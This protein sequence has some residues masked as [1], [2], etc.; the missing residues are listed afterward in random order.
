MGGLP[1]SPTRIILNQGQFIHPKSQ[2]LLNPGD[3]LTV[4]YPGGGGFGP[5]NERERWAIEEDLKEE[6]ISSEAAR[7]IY[8]LK[9][10]GE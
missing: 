3:R 10:K 6:L 5:T 1:G 9:I 4:N 7:E 8:G 2:T